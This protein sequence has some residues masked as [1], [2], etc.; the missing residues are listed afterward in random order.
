MGGKFKFSAQKNDLAPFVGNGTK[1]KI[2]SEFQ[3]PLFKGG[4]KLKKFMCAVFF[5]FLVHISHLTCLV[6]YYS[7]WS[8]NRVCWHFFELVEVELVVEFMVGKLVRK[9]CAISRGWNKKSRQIKWC[10]IK[11]RLRERCVADCCDC[12]IVATEA[13][14]IM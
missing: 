5:I 12:E 10:A 13:N 6:S 11:K 7:F 2:L 9:N 3:P 1:V 14:G 4:K 8:L